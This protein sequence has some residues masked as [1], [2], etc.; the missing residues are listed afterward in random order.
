[1]G[2]SDNNVVRDAFDKG[3]VRMKKRISE[4]DIRNRKTIQERQKERFMINQKS[5]VTI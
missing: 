4:S 2:S 1:M 3:R 5:C